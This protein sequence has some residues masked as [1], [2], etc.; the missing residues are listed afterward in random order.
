GAIAPFTNDRGGVF[1]HTCML[2]EAH[3]VGETNVLYGNHNAGCGNVDSSSRTNNLDDAC[4]ATVHSADEIVSDLRLGHR[5]F[6]SS[7]AQTCRRRF[8]CPA[9]SPAA[10]TCPSHLFPRTSR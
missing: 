5:A 10:P 6:I 8:R 9:L 2:H 1:A 3:T 4:S 7:S